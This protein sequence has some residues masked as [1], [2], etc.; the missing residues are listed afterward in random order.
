MY[1]VLEP[2]AFRRVSMSIILLLLLLWDIVLHNI[3]FTGVV[4]TLKT[5][6]RDLRNTNRGEQVVPRVKLEIL[7]LFKGKVELFLFLELYV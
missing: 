7:T 4:S 5:K 2:S 1:G 3:R 6:G